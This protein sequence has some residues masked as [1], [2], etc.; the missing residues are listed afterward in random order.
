MGKIYKLPTTKNLEFFHPE[1][2]Y[3]ILANFK[4][5]DGFRSS[6]RERA[7]PIMDENLHITD[8]ELLLTGRL[9][10]GK[11]NPLNTIERTLAEYIRDYI[12][13]LLNLLKKAL[14]FIVVLK[15]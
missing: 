2:K 8:W 11:I 9:D 13:L 1:K 7:N 10:F 6:V 3:A 12:N 5:R 15:K 4:H 14:V